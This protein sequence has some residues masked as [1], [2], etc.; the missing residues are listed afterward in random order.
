[1]ECPSHKIHEFKCPTNKNDFSNRGLA[2][3]RVN[4]TLRYTYPGTHGAGGV[5]S[6]L[7]ALKV[8]A[9]V[10]LSQQPG[11]EGARELGVRGTVTRAVRGPV[12]TKANCQIVVS[13]TFWVSQSYVLNHCFCR[14]NDEKNQHLNTSNVVF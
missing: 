4:G 1:V 3:L 5:S 11:T 13:K 12:Q 6:H 7:L 10:S 2:K 9:G 8:E 14:S